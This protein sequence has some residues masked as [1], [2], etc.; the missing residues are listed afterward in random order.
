MIDQ[1]TQYEILLFILISCQNKNEEVNKNFNL[2]LLEKLHFL[3]FDEPNIILESRF[4]DD[5]LAIKEHTHFKNGK[6]VRLVKY[7]KN[8]NMKMDIPISKTS[9]HGIVIHYNEY[10]SKIK[11]VSMRYEKIHGKSYTFHN[12]GDKKIFINNILQ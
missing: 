5:S 2:Y 10:G 1:N 12:L 6:V 3:R 4:D 8:G 11:E 7:H 9:Y